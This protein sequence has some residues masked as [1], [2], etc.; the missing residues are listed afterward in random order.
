MDPDALS[1]R[2]PRGRS[3]AILLD[4]ENKAAANRIR[5]DKPD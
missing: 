2:A 1:R 4:A 5:F 3:R